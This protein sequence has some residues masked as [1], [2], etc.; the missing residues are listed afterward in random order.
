[1]QETVLSIPWGYYDEGETH[2]FKAYT[3]V[4]QRADK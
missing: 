4:V 2:S 3:P 1:M